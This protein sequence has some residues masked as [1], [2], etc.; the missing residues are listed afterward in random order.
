MP[1][2][3]ITAN[4]LAMLEKY[5]AKGRLKRH[6][7]VYSIF[8]FGNH[9]RGSKVA[10]QPP[11][12]PMLL[13][14]EIHSKPISPC[15]IRIKGLQTS[16]RACIRVG[17]RIKSSSRVLSS[18]G[19]HVPVLTTSYASRRPRWI[20]GR[21]QKSDRMLPRKEEGRAYDRLSLFILA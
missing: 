7:V 16:I 2:P 8:G 4:H 3:I 9:I 13:R 14:Y 1:V 18:I 17:T 12:P 20:H 21:R 6:C 15:T 5:E 19:F 10:D 11:P